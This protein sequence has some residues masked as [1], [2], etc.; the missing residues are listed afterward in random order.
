MKSRVLVI[1]LGEVGKP[2]MEVLASTYDIKGRDIEYESVDDV[3]VMH[4]CYPYQ[5]ND[6]IGTTV[7]NVEEYAPDLVII[8]STV[9]PGT[10]RK[11]RE[12]SK[13][14]TVFSPVRGKHVCMGEELLH[15]TK[16]V[17]GTDPD[18]TRL[19]A[20]HFEKAGMKV[21]TMSSCEAL[22]L[23]KLLETTYFGVLVAWAQETERFCNKLAVDYDEVMRFTEEIRYLP[24]VILQPGYIGGHCVIPNIRLLEQLRPSEFTE[25][26]RGSNEV[27]A[28]EWEEAGRS[29]LDRIRPIEKK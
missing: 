23:A 20:E 8:N 28:R 21:G 9:L 17:G 6:F 22:E 24:P 26:I 14:P 1:G 18:S 3:S 12:I 29:L 25:A 10:T 16:Y 4:V 2:L 27:K 19:A 13:T 5:I 15:Y 7:E 11:I